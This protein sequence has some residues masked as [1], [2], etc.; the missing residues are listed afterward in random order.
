MSLKQ[1]DILIS[2]I[3]ALLMSQRISWSIE[4]FISENHVYKSFC[5]QLFYRPT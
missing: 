1:S 3:R 5:K 4:I 2:V